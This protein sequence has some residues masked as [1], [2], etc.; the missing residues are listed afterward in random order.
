MAVERC[1]DRSEVGRAGREAGTGAA[2]AVSGRAQTPE[3]PG[4]GEGRKE[5]P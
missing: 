3:W 2:A 4:H 5:G 1:Q